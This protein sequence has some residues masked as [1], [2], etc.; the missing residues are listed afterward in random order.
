M[1]TL[2]AYYLRILVAIFLFILILA[3]IFKRY[4]KQRVSFGSDGRRMSA[5]TSM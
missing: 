3:H 5:L 4:K 1:A 2:Q